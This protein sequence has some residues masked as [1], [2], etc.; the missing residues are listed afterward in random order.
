MPY[1]RHPSSAACFPAPSGSRLRPLVGHGRAWPGIRGNRGKAL[2]R[3]FRGSPF[4][5]PNLSHAYTE[6]S[7]T[8]AKKGRV[9]S[10]DL[11]A[12]LHAKSVLRTCRK[13]SEK[14]P[15]TRWGPPCYGLSHP[16]LSVVY[17]KNKEFCD[18]LPKSIFFV[19]FQ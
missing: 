14:N 1:Y 15:S 18:F 17:S 12:F 10:R 19:F 16:N 3:I 13:N 11:A 5:A 8:S 6:N 2:G 4:F 7:E 9:G